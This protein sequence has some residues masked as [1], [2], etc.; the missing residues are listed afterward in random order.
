LKSLGES[1]RAKAYALLLV[2]LDQRIP[3]YGVL[4]GT[5]SD[6]YIG[7]RSVFGSIKISLHESGVCR[8]ALTEKH[9][10]QADQK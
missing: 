5:K 6:Y 4:F 3:I 10:T 2:V 1:S 8:L 7:A 9:M